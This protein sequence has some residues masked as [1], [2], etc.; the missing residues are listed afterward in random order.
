VAVNG[1]VVGAIEQGL[2]VLIGIAAADGPADIEYIAS[3]VRDMR[4]FADDDGR[5]NRSINEAAG[6][7]LVISEFT[8]MGDVRKGRRPSFDAAADPAT[9]R[10]VFEKVLERMRRDGPVETGTFQAH[11]AVTLVNDGPVTILLDSQ[12]LF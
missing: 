11:M 6:S 3:K 4:I 8:L 2:V 5:M 9:A 10:G 7:V 12:R 1:N